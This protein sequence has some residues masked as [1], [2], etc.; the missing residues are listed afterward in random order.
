[1]R[2]Y[3]RFYWDAVLGAELPDGID[4]AV[5]DFAVNSGPGRAAKYLQAVLGVA[6]DGRIGPATLGAARARPAGVVI[7]A[8]CDAR[9]AFLERLPTWPTFGKGW[10]ARIASVRANALLLTARPV[11]PAHSAPQATAPVAEQAAAG[12]RADGARSDPP[13]QAP[14]GKAARTLALTVLALGAVAAWTAHLPCNL[15]GVFCK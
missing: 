6:R 4:Y 9:L 2:T 11:V 15:L 5:F 14:P 8:L 10:R 13:R 1:M 12:A 3:R 7:D